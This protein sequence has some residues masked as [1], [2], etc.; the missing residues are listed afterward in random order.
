MPFGSDGGTRR[1]EGPPALEGRAW[2]HPSELGLRANEGPRVVLRA[3]PPRSRL[4]VAAAVGLLLGT[5][6]T[7]AGAAVSGNLGDDESS[8]VVERLASPTSRTVPAN[9]L[10]VAAASLPSIVRV[11]AQGPGG[12]RTGTAA[13]VRNDGVMVTTSDVLDGAE[14][15]TVTLDDGSSYDARLLGRHRPTDLGVIDIEAE[16]LPVV[17]LPDARVSEAVGFGDPV[18]LVDTSP[19]AASP[20]LIA[21]IVSV[22]STA[23]PATAIRTTTAGAPM[24]GM[25]EVQLPPRSE[26]PTGGILLDANGSLVGVV[27]TRV[28]AGGDS[29][30]G[31]RGTVVYATPFD[32]ARNVYADVLA[33]G[34]Y[35]AADLP[36][37]VETVGGTEARDLDLPGSGGA[38]VASS[39]TDPSLG[40]AFAVGDVITEIG[41]IAVL[42]VNDARTELRRYEAGEEVTVVIVRDGQTT[43][44][45][46]RLGTEGSAP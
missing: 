17:A 33:N 3:R 19:D 25:I 12:T 4:L 15:I 18:V 41:G 6:L 13:L 22:P 11:E 24:Y 10:A 39:P 5:G 40:E 16:G 27:T 38:V 30:E 32:H 7:V 26:V 21:G 35:T 9:Q 20:V 46:V 1:E 23:V 36:L 31:P 2:R 29:D 43:T 28:Q 14:N 37:K 42:D 8:T 45:T 34:R 44:R